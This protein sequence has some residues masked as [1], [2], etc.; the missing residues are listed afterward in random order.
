MVAYIQDLCHSQRA[1]KATNGCLRHSRENVERAEAE[2]EEKWKNGG[3]RGKR[4]H[5]RKGRADE[6]TKGS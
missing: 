1:E 5:L 4:G 2:R 3:M 6:E